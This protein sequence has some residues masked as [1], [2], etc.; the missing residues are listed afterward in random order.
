MDKKQDESL[1]AQKRFNSLLGS[2]HA[3]FAKEKASLTDERDSF[4]EHVDKIR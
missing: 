4:Q 1:D 2:L 3:D